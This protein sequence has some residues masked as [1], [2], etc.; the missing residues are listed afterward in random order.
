MINTIPKVSIIVPIH[1]AGERLTACLDTLI[2][3]SLQDIEIILVLDCPTDGSDI[4]AKQYAEKDKRIVIL[5]NQINLHIGNSRNRGLEIAKGEYI[6]F[7]DHDD[8]REL[9][10]YEK[11]YNNAQTT[12]SDIVLGISVSVGI[13]NETVQFP[14]SFSNNDLREYALIDLVS[15]GDDFT[16]MPR[17]T[18][19]HPNIYKSQLLRDNNISF[20]NTNLYTPEDRIFQIM[21]LYYSKIVSLYTEPLYYHII[22]P[23]SAGQSTL[24][25]SYQS[26]AN[27]KLKI[28]EFLKA[29]DCYEKYE[30][31]FLR[32]TKKEFVNCIIDVFHSTKS[33]NKVFKAIK[34]LKSFP[35]CKKAFKNTFYSLQRYRFGGKLFRILISILMC[36]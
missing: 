30:P 36:L 34:Y 25:Q 16:L 1:N 19:I 10:M 29:N 13:Q 35:F 28:Y 32:A 9:T 18:N 27:G 14:S 22:Y 33:I 8:Y 7:S 5:E 15:G 6:G 31:E 2:Q 11:L 20:V 23:E 21:C 4:I 24:Y 26:R 17:A 12:N 3:Q